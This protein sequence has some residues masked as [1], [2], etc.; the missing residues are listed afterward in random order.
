M[1]HVLPVAHD[2]ALRMAVLHHVREHSSAEEHL[3]VK[4]IEA[5]LLMIDAQTMCLRRGGSSMRI[6]NL[7]SLDVSPCPQREQGSWKQ[8]K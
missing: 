3:V 6:L 5:A 2:A 1:A 4:V 8:E 7:D